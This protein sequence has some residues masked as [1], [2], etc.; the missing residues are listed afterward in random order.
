MRCAECGFR[1]RGN[2]HE[3]GMH[4]NLMRRY[5]GQLKRDQKGNIVKRVSYKHYN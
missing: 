5:A 3:N 2:N 1:V 4:H